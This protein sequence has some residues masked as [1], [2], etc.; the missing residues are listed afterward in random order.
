MR[1]AASWLS[2]IAILLGMLVALCGCDGNPVVQTET[3]VVQA[4]V[5]PTDN[6]SCLFQYFEYNG[7]RGHIRYTHTELSR[8]Q[9]RYLAGT[10]IP[11]TFI[12]R[13]Y[14]NGKKSYELIYTPSLLPK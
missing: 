14:E 3:E 12:T 4:I 9:W 8:E 13:T 11:M 1:W 2:I 7:V 10:T 6:N 5:I